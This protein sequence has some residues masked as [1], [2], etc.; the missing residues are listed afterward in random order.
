MQGFKKRSD[1]LE[2]PYKYL[3]AKQNFHYWL[4]FFLFDLASQIDACLVL[5]S[6]KLIFLIKDNKDF[7]SFLSST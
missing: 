7:P 2:C 3:H 5:L 1:K 4:H 6:M